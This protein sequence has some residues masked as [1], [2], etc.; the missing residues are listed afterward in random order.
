M[1]AS[2]IFFTI[3]TL[4]CSFDYFSSKMN[5]NEKPKEGFQEYVFYFLS[6]MTHQGKFFSH[7]IRKYFHSI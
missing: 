6:L 7:A 1:D 5:S 2:A 3:L 4:L